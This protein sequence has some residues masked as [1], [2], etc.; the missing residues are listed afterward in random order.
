M[1]GFED[2]RMIHPQISQMT[3]IIELEKRLL[4]ESNRCSRRDGGCR[5]AR[6]CN[7]ICV[8]CEICG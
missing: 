6:L 8:I 1:R 5:I 4:W 3:L 2:R 7:S